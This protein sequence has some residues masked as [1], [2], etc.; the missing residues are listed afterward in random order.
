M[1]WERTV[2][3]AGEEE[4]H[5]CEFDARGAVVEGEGGMR[6]RFVV[7]RA[8]CNSRVLVRRECTAVLMALSVVIGR[9]VSGNVRSMRG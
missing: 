3:A 5:C 1:G 6:L 2:C 8:Y 9:F 7:G 4:E